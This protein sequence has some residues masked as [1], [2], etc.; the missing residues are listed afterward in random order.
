MCPLKCGVN[1]G[2]V[3]RAFPPIVDE[4]ERL[5]YKREFDED[6]QEYKSLQAELDNIN[7]VLAQLDREMNTHAEGSPQFLVRCQALAAL[8][9]STVF[10]RLAAIVNTPLNES[11]HTWPKTHSNE[12]ELPD[13]TMGGW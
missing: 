4:E 10:T 8:Q 11:R 7:Q 9:R 6:H 13:L 2:V 3:C 5:N 1:G 12:A